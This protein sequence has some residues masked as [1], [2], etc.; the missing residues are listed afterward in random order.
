M[1]TPP[2]LL[3]AALIFWG[4]Q[5]DLI[6]IAVIM[7]LILEGSR[8]I[9]F[10]FAFSQE[11]VNRFSDLSSISFAGMLIYLFATSRSAQSVITL[12]MWMPIALL[13]LF[14]SQVYSTKE[15]I[16]ISALFLVLRSKSRGI[17]TRPV[18]LNISY[19]YF[20]LCILSAS[21]ANSRTIAFYGGLLIL[22]AWSMWSLRSRRF[23]SILWIA[24][25]LLSGVVGYAGQFGLHRLQLSL[26]E[27]ALT[28]FADLFPKDLNPYK[29]RTAIG[30]LGRL[31]LSDSILFRVKSEN[32]HGNSILLREASYKAYR[33]SMWFATRTKFEELK[34]EGDASTW[35]V[36]KNT[37]YEDQTLTISQPLKRGSGMLK[38]PLT[39]FGIEDLPVLKLTKNQYGAFKVEDGPGLV[40][41][42]VK[43]GAGVTPDSPPDEADL[44]IPP[45][46]MGAILKI[47]QELDLK[48]ASPDEALQLLQNYL[49]EEYMYSLDL[50]GK[51]SG[52]TPLENFL[53]NSRKGHC[54]F[55]ATATVLILRA[56]GIPARYAVG[57]SVHEFSDLEDFFV[58]R[59]R[60]AHA[61]AMVYIDGAWKNFDTTPIS[62]VTAEE[63]TASMFEPFT[64]FLSYTFY[65]FS[66]WR[67]SER[68]EGL[69]KYLKWLLIP[70]VFFILHR[71]YSRKRISKESEEKEGK[72]IEDIKKGT[73]SAFY[74]IEEKLVQ[75][76]YNRRTSETFTDWLNRIEKMNPQMVSYRNLKSLLD[77][78]YRYRFDPKG[79]TKNE[80]GK[81]KSDVQLW[82]EQYDENVSYNDL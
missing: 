51:K 21:A 16:D 12:I 63:E 47:V 76:G 74:L 29:A 38:L 66:R 61:W 58:V 34:P 10:R 13:P 28:S 77:T 72:E 56:M 43:F 45:A 64:D 35:R 62:W 11:D 52:V 49:Q 68:E 46:E 79:I 4:W 36:K 53:L 15:K 48:S 60:H 67:W 27:L 3:G 80:K 37:D 41:Y 22:A 1:I 69:L 39:V 5:T 30:E 40:N 78:H 2:L 14:I 65:K 19:L 71:F 33:N 82:L 50:A 9:K 44:Y 6:I 23:S 24:L 7:A 26:E 75:A 59:S 31:K 55:F 54:E 20:A 57:Y 70:L 25:L 17:K 18:E 73:D 81:F 42:R 8:I 32:Y